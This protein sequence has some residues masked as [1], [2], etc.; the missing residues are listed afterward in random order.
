[1]TTPPSVMAG[2]ITSVARHTVMQCARMKGVG[3]FCVVMGL[4]LAALPFAMTGDGTLAGRIRSFLSYGTGVLAAGLSILTI[5]LSVYV[6]SEDVRSRQVFS[7]VVKPVAR[8]QYILGRWLGVSVL[9]GGMLLIG[10]VAVFGMAQYLRAGVLAPAKSPLDHQAVETE[11][12]TARR[13]VSPVP[14]DIEGMVA[15]RIEEMQEKKTLDDALEV[16]RART[17]G[18]EA[19]AEGALL[20]ELAKDTANKQNSIAPGKSRSWEFE[21]IQTGG[22]AVRGVGQIVGVDREAEAVYID[23]PPNV[24]ARALYGGP[25]GIGSAV[26]G[27]I[28][29]MRGTTIEIVLGFEDMR[30]P[31]IT[32]LSPGDGVQLTIDPTIQLTY[33]AQSASRAQDDRLTSLWRVR[34]PTSPVQSF[35]MRHDLNDTPATMT[36]S[37]RVVSDD[38]R[39]RVTYNNMRHRTTGQLTS[40]TILP[41]DV[42]ILFRVGSFAG[43]YARGIFLLLL[44]LMYL[45]GVGVFAGSFLMFPVGCLMS[46]SLLPFSM[47]AEFIRD[48]TD[49]EF[50]AAPLAF[51][52]YIVRAMVILLPDFGSTSPGEWLVNGMAI[53]SGLIGWAVLVNLLLRT[54]VPLGLACLIFRR[55]ELAKVHA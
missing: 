24:L 53:P 42:A 33:R 45:A 26:E 5:F 29:R 16:Y 41:R 30:K 8:W 25:I 55:R 51:S 49:P 48:A 44:Q 1:M 32:A 34:N 46:F 21:G 7:V 6:V 22:R 15:K 54:G 35:E 28:R 18:N 10:A 36:I 9:S 31:A 37:A 17:G 14:D 23:A 4:M 39:A 12:F 47:A 38:G 19:L 27:R 3:V 52:H 13:R 43:N 2:G 50:L 40:V 20:T 11:V